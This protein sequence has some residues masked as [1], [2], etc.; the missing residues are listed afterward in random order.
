[1]SRANAIVVFDSLNR[2][3]LNAVPMTHRAQKQ[4][5]TDPRTR[6]EWAADVDIADSTGEEI[7]AAQAD[8]AKDM[9][10]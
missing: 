7:A 4:A 10:G 5:L 9:D 3:D 8:V 1:L 6:F 2:T